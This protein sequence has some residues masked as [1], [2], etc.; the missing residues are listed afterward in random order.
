[1]RLPVLF[2][3]L[4]LALVVV[5]TSASAWE[6]GALNRN[7]RLGMSG[8]DVRL[9]QVILNSDP[10]TKIA[11][12]GSGSPGSESNYFG[13]R[14]KAAMA[15]FQELYRSE[16]LAPAGLTRGS[17]YVGSYSR[18]KLVSL[19]KGSGATSSATSPRPVTSTRPTTP[20]PS[21]APV[22][23]NA[24]GVPLSSAALSR[25]AS[26]A[27]KP[28]IMFPSSY[29]VRQG[30][31]LTVYGGGFTPSDNTISIGATRYTNVSPTKGALEITIP[32]NAQ[33][34]K[35][36]LT[37]SNA[38]GESNKTFVVITDPSAPSPK[39]L[40][41]TPSAGPVGTS[42]TVT[43]ENLSKEWNDVVVGQRIITGV[44]SPDGKSLTFTP[45]LPVPGVSSGQ[46]VPNVKLESPLWFYIVNP[47]GVT[48]S[49]VFTVKI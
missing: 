40:S 3:S 13:A 9:L 35:F 22:V 10:R 34:G 18:T 38:K 31:K 5:P 16:V 36:S 43:G 41:F 8:E 23:S 24:L 6:C 46:D 27:R 21:L 25:S 49:S 29:A 1:M 12:S 15:R 20:R 17:G 4:S 19:C 47:N 11:D 48:G 33:K 44:V 28:Y 2:A 37:V 26:R 32:R 30:G 39:V 42:I 7:L 45:N 14:T